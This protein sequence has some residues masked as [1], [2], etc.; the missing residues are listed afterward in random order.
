LGLTGL[1]FG[2]R[3]KVTDDGSAHNGIKKPLTRVSQ[4]F[5]E[6][7]ETWKKMCI[8]LNWEFIPTV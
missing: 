5:V 4:G 1:G 6:Q 7:D 8:E 3:Q 2:D